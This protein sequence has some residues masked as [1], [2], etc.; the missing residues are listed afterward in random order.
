M[1]RNELLQ[2]NRSLTGTHDGIRSSRNE[3]SAGAIR[4]TCQTTLRCFSTTGEVLS[5]QGKEVVKETPQV[6]L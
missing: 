3:P 4:R 1:L 5:G 6:I 2:V